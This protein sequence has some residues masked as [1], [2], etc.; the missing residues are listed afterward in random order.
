[1]CLFGAPLI[2]CT[3][4]LADAKNP[5][6]L[7]IQGF[8]VRLDESMADDTVLPKYRDMM[9]RIARDP[10]GQTVLFELIMRLFFIHV[11][12]VR[13]ECLENRRK[14]QRRKVR[15]WCNDG[16][17]ASSSAPGAFG[18][19]L[20]FRGEIEAQ[21][22]GSLHPHVL[23]WLVTLT[24][25]QVLT[26]LKKDQTSFKK[27][28]GNWMRAAVAAAESVN[29]S[30]VQALPRQFGDLDTRLQPPAFN[31]TQQRLTRFD[32]GSELDEIR[33]LPERTE[34]QEELLETEVDDDW[35]RPSFPLRDVAGNVLEAAAPDTVRR[36][37]Y[38]MR[39]DEF[40]VAKFPRYRRQGALRAGAGEQEHDTEDDVSNGQMSAEVWQRMLSAD[41]L[42]LVS[43]L[44]L[45]ICGESCYKYS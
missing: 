22:R 42:K 28:L 23:V 21:G 33:A 17:A 29:Q 20:A 41:V 45:H 3:P 16:V 30:S 35:R 25:A 4:N 14:A 11:L 19:I 26:L 13:P 1:M 12:G 8:E 38:N 18:P 39:L 37:V 2:F 6:L 10:V 44:L 9:R 7:I 5:L 34:L 36:S 27:N 15:E 24:L 31:E 43:E 32:G 40:E